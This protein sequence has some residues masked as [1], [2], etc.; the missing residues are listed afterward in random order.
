VLPP[1]RKPKH[2][3]ENILYLGKSTRERTK[4]KIGIKSKSELFDTSNVHRLNSQKSME[5]AANKVRF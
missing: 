1:Q 2:N 4:K 5:K 3:N